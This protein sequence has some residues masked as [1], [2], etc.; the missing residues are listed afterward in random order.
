MTLIEKYFTGK[1][2]DCICGAI[3][4]IALSVYAIMH[5]PAFLDVTAMTCNF[6]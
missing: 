6:A 4:Y 1:I 3:A 2:A 5:V